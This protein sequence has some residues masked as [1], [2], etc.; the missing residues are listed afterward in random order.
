MTITCYN[1]SVPAGGSRHQHRRHQCVSKLMRMCCTFLTCVTS[2][3]DDMII[4]VV[5]I[6]R[7]SNKMSALENEMFYVLKI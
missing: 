3:V 2:D 4:C 7:K 6:L 1:M 5:I